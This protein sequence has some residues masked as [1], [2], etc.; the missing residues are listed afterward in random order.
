MKETTRYAVLLF[1]VLTL[2]TS[3]YLA[4]NLADTPSEA[5]SNGEAP[6]QINDTEEIGENESETVP[7]SERPEPET[8]IGRSIRGFQIMFEDIQRASDIFADSED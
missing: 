1:G 2:L 6:Q 5:A 3:S 4:I 8:L 7:P